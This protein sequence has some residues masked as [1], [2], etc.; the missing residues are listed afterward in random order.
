MK[1]ILASNNKGK[2][3]EMKAIFEAM[4]HELVSQSEAGLSLEAEETGETFKENALIKAKA[5]AK[6][7][8]FPAVS[9]D[10]GL[11]VDALSGLPGVHSARYGGEACK[12]D[13]DRAAFLLKNMQDEENRSARF[14]SCI[15][16]V[17][18]NGDEI[19]SEGSCEGSISLAPR[20]ENGFGY[21]PVFLLPNGKTMAEITDSEKNR[22]SHRAA[23]LRNFEMKLREYYADK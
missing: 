22:I 21:D 14:V 11:I 6:A 7:L 16:C 9:D 12:S 15:A 19:T 20:G 23:A 18:P 2:L 10:S 17:F 1:F 3:K 8:P 4:G 13:G 5:A